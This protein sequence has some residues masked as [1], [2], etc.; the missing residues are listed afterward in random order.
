MLF[1]QNGNLPVRNFRDGLFPNVRNVSGVGI[2][3]TVRIGM[4]GCYAC[5][6]RCKKVVKVDEPYI[7][8]PA[9]GGPEHETLGALGSDCGVD[10]TRILCKA[11]ERCNAYGIDT[12]STGSSIAFAIECYERGL[13]TKE[14]TGGLE[15]KF[16]DAELVLKLVGMI[17]RCEGFGQFIA[18]GTARMAKKIGHGSEQFA[19]NVKGLESAMHDARV[20][21]GFRLG[22]M[23]NP[24]GADHCSSMGGGTNPVGINNYNQFGIQTPIKEDF[25]PKRMSLFKLNHC[26]SIVNDSMVLC[27][28]PYTNFSQ[29]LDLLR[30]VTGWDTSWVELIQIGERI[31]TL[32]RLFNN[33]EGFTDADDELPER[34]Y[35]HKTNGVLATKDIPDKTTMLKARQSYYFFMGWDAQG[36]PRPEKIAELEIEMLY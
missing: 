29:K 5:S 13:L 27:L 6:I 18:Q 34:F 9:Y 33:R 8:D 14:D 25:G 15:L 19:M 10:D 36:V 28:M 17:A 26:I 32:M 24:H 22:Y 7:V 11:S 2:K 20:M 30:A 23:L 1:E 35:Q 16:D 3:E 31:L 4:E 21:L 12:I